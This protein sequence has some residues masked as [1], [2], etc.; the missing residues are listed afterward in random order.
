MRDA[1][2]Q[3]L[4]WS[5]LLF[6]E[7]AKGHYIYCSKRTYANQDARSTFNVRNVKAGPMGPI[8]VHYHVYRDCCLF[9]RNE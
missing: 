2:Y 8:L 7:G 6:N 5:K 3:W 4:S 1:P 9:N